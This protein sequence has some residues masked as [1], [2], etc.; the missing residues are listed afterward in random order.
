VGCLIGTWFHF[1]PCIW[2]TCDWGYYDGQGKTI[3]NIT[4]YIL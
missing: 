4:R 2:W 3:T 1:I